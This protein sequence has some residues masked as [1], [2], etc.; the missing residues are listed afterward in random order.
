MSKSDS[1]EYVHEVW[2]NNIMNNLNFVRSEWKFKNMLGMIKQF[3]LL[4]IITLSFYVQATSKKK[5][6]FNCMNL[7][8]CQKFLFS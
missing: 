2:I 1:W 3:L 8:S 4:G 7:E 6:Y 5:K